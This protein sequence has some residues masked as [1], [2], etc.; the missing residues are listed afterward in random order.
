M[1]VD[2]ATAKSSALSCGECNKELK[3]RVSFCP[4][5]GKRNRS[6]SDL[7]HVIPG[8][9]GGQYTASAH[10]NVLALKGDGQGS[11]ESSG[12]VSSSDIVSL[13]EPFTEG[14]SAGART[15]AA[16]ASH[17]EMRQPE[18]SPDAGGGEN[19]TQPTGPLPK[20]WRWVL[21]L[22]VL[23]VIAFATLRPEPSGDAPPG[24]NSSGSSSSNDRV[25]KPQIIIED[26]VSS[27]RLSAQWQRVDIPTD[28]ARPMIA[29]SSKQPFRMRVNGELYFIAAQTPLLIRFGR[30]SFMELKALKGSADVRIIRSAMK[31]GG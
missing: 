27:V 25:P 13:G 21:L 3:A 9:L 18:D 29:V 17:R 24:A 1:L 4:F 8:G 6:E 12:S 16:E 30:A 19:H 11:P 10:M 15:L 22:G 23:A 14:N 31:E 2:G 5:C 7:F 20:V 28:P 26:R